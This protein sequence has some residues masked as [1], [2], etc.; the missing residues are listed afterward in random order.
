MALTGETIARRSRQHK[1]KETIIE[2]F[3]FMLFVSKKTS[4]NVVHQT[5]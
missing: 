2:S 5:L 4:A 3:H 1:Q